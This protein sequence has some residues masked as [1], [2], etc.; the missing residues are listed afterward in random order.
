M[1]GVQHNTY[2]VEFYGPNPQCGIYYLGALRA[3]EEM[4][5]AVGDTQAA[6]DY[7]KLFES[8]RNWI[9]AN[10]FNGHYYI[11]KV[12]SIPKDQ[13]APAT[14]G[15]MG[16][17]RP[18]KPDFQVGDGCL[19][20]QLMGQYISEVAGLGP[21]VDPAHI[22][23][24]LRSIYQYNYKRQLFDHESVQR[25]YVLNDEA[26]LVVCDYGTGK[27]PEIPFPYFAEA[28]TG[29]EYQAAAHMIYAGMVREGI[30]CFENSRHR[31]DGE[32]RNPW[33]EAECGHHYARAMSA[34]SGVL[35]LNGFRYHAAEK[36]AS[37]TPRVSS[38]KFSCF[39]SAAAAWGTFSH[40]DE[41]G[42]RRLTLSV[43]EGILPLRSVTLAP[44]AAAPSTATV[45]GRTVDHE[46][47]RS[48]A[49]MSFA[50]ADEITVRA[51]EDLVLLA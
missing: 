21:L 4:A 9:D 30:E 37:I 27:R 41:N 1:D 38:G 33:D 46:L 39:W 28:W 48:D 13:I 47:K 16:T 34:W 22:R 49:A 2:D 50:F 15:D 36:S 17:D 45:G 12:R 43:A 5:R 14:V 3:G 31:Y 29:L 10:L 26:A 24:A 40:T 32:R 6:E 42:R 23:E 25:T 19:L 44:G 11:Q 18:D 8:G 51:G 7:R 35:A 20:D